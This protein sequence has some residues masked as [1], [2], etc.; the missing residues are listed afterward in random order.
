MLSFRERAS[1]AWRILTARPSGLVDYAERE[2]DIANDH[3][4]P[5]EEGP[6][7]EPPRFDSFQRHLRDL[8]LVFSTYGHSGSSAPIAI[9]T[10]ARLAKFKPLSPL[11]GAESEWMPV[12]QGTSPMWQ[13]RRYGA[14]FRQQKVDNGPADRWDGDRISHE[15]YDVDA[16]VFKGPDGIA[17]SS[18]NS[19]RDGITMPY[20][21]P[22]EAEVIKVDEG[23][24]PIPKPICIAPDLVETI[25]ELLPN[26][27]GGPVIRG[28]LAAARG[29]HR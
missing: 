26:H 3:D 13:N 29:V 1:L 8:L 23:G 15:F 28:A 11:T 24:A 20:E 14:V 5:L 21:V 10:F 27:G 2:F 25:E 9:A 12:E 18:P 16:F 19:L 7:N 6:F 17:Y 4:Y 22:D